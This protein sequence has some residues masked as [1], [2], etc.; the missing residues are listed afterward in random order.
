MDE[1]RGKWERVVVLAWSLGHLVPIE[2][3][4]RD[5]KIIDK[6]ANEVEWRLSCWQ[7]ITSCSGS[8]RRRNETPFSVGG[9]GWSLASC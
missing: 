2:W 7:R 5:F 8:D 6:L 4:A 1:S 3:I 9:P